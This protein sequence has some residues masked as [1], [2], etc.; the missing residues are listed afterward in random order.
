MVYAKIEKISNGWIVECS[1]EYG[2]TGGDRYF[3]T[4]DGAM[5]IVKGFLKSEEE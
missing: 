4:L 1:G 5:E 2:L 3:E